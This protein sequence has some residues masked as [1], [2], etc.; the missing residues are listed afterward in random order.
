MLSILDRMQVR[1]DLVLICNACMTNRNT[2]VTTLILF[3]TSVIQALNNRIYTRYDF[4]FIRYECS[5]GFQQP[6]YTRYDF[7]FTRYG[8]ITV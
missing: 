2:S 6:Y 3:V 8:C 7:H 4:H 1:N 5:T